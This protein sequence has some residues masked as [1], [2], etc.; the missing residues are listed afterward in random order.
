MIPQTRVDRNTMISQN[1]IYSQTELLSW[2]VKG[3]SGMVQNDISKMLEN[4][5][6]T[7]NDLIA[8]RTYTDKEFKRCIKEL[9]NLRTATLEFLDNI[10]QQNQT[11]ETGRLFSSGLQTYHEITWTKKILDGKLNDQNIFTIDLYDNDTKQKITTFNVT[12][13]V[14]EYN[15]TK[16]IG[17]E[18]FK[19]P[20]MF[21]Y[22]H[23]TPKTVE[24][25]WITCRR[26]G[27]RDITIKR[28]ECDYCWNKSM[29]GE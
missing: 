5:E 11:P 7:L 15:D 28:N 21:V 8:S 19:E 6:Q 26:C 12:I 18:C 4:G 10:I 3:L 20:T 25:N 1:T 16:Y 27:K 13:E 17:P 23:A 14:D 2:K 24:D 29:N 22:K 9:Y